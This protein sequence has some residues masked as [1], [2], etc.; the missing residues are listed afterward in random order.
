MRG[1]GRR[2]LR[3]HLASGLLVGV[4][5]TEK[6]ADQTCGMDMIQRTRYATNVSEFSITPE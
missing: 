2:E 4:K 1:Q 3:F 6:R 5:E